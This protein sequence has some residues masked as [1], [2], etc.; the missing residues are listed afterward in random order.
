M[1]LHFSRNFNPRL[2]VAASRYLNAPVEYC[3]AAPF[4]PAQSDHFR[5]L[6]LSLRIPILEED[7]RPP[8][9]EADAIACRLSQIVGSSF[10]RGGEAL[11]DMI[12]WLSWG[13]NYFVRS[14]DL[15]HWERVTKQRYGI[16]PVRPDFLAEGLAGFA[17]AAAQL[18]AHLT[19]RD[20][21]LKDGLS[22]ADF[23]MACVLP[24]ADVAALPLSD[25]PAVQAWHDR[26]MTLAAWADPFA[27]LDAP[28]LP[29]I[30][31]KD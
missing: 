30:R 27:G 25:Y 13:H 15:V 8:L 9:W 3:F 14:C 18:D 20:W 12:R 1:R 2:A 31:A 28:Q 19:G 5:K 24:Y 10:W 4:D 7:D 29:E 22:Y 17:E 26:L 23:R 16:G 11:P 21:L 6:N